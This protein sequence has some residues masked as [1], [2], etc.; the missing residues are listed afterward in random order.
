MQ[1]NP[2][3]YSPFVADEAAARTSGPEKSPLG[4]EPDPTR[5]GFGREGDPDREIR[6]KLLGAAEE[7]P[8]QGKTGGGT[9]LD[10]LLSTR[11]IFCP[12]CGSAH[13]PSEHSARGVAPVGDG[14][15]PVAG[16]VETGISTS[17]S[18][19]PDGAIAIS[20]PGVESE[21]SMDEDDD[22]KAG[23]DGK[24]EAVEESEETAGPAE[25]SEEEK[26]KVDELEKRDREVRQHE[27]AHMAAG[28]QYVRGG[29]SY[30]YENGPDGK[31]YAVGGEVSIDTSTVV[32]DPQA[33]IRKAQAIRRAA[34]APAE[35]SGQDRSV[36]AS[37]SRM[38]T[39]ARQELSEDRMEEMADG[40]GESDEEDE[41]QSAGA[42]ELLGAGS[43][44]SDVPEIALP[45]A[46][47]ES[48]AGT[49][50][51]YEL[52]G[53]ELG[54]PGEAARIG[55]ESDD[56]VGLNP[57]G[58]EEEAGASGVLADLKEGL[59]AAAAGQVSG[60]S[61]EVGGLSSVAPGEM[62]EKVEIIEIDGGDDDKL[63]PSAS[64]SAGPA[65]SRLDYGP[66]PDPGQILDVYR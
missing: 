8:G 26:A 61:R 27:Q 30:E 11:S 44:E 37:A 22:S 56:A 62:I 24:P 18:A 45:G 42:A 35:P 55:R 47:S 17:G 60:D 14:S 28:G 34:L 38:E 31:R 15:R 33:T 29:A 51:P 63:E 49:G 25:L 3:T 43:T 50:V 6:E 20:V 36:A 54:L 64:G 32:D 58:E 12:I 39:Q 19:A 52:L 65:V 10:D 16:P 4:Q 59:D 21:V 40:V 1:V 46:D 9:P 53:G 23:R 66:K 2:T 48:E 5:V 13:A 41:P 57:V 7:L